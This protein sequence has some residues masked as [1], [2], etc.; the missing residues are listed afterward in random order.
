LRQGQPVAL[1]LAAQP[2]EELRQ[3]LKTRFEAMERRVEA[4]EALP[5]GPVPCGSGR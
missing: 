4:A 5:A 1:A 2:E 3:G